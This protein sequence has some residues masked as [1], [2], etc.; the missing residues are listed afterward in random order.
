LIFPA[1][2]MVAADMNGMIG[3]DAFNDFCH[4]QPSRHSSAMEVR[5]RI[6]SYANVI[7][8]PCIY[9]PRLSVFQ[10]RAYPEA[11]VASDPAP[12]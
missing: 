12:P 4:S 3:H 9:F 2:V 6:P 1:A 8:L 7:D 5:A 10:A 11:G